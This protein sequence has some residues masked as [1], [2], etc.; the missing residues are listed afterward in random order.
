[1]LNNDCTDDYRDYV[2]VYAI[3]YNNRRTRREGS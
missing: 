2:G 3:V 1:M